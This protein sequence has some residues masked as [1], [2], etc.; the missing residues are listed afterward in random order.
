[1]NPTPLFAYTLRHLVLAFV[2]L[3]APLAA[4]AQQAAQFVGTWTTGLTAMRQEGLSTQ[5]GE[6]GVLVQTVRV[7]VGGDFARLRLSNVFGESELVITSA[8]LSRLGKEDIN[9]T[10]ASAGRTPV[11][12]ANQSGLSIPAGG[13]AVSDPLRFAIAADT[14]V[15]IT[16]HIKK[17]PRILTGH[18]SSGAPAVSFY[19]PGSAE[20][21]GKPFLRS[22]R[23]YFI[24]GLD[25]A[26]LK[27]GPQYRPR[28]VVA[29][30]DSITDG[31]GVPPS[32]NLRWSD[33]LSRRLRAHPATADVGVL[34]VGIGGNRLLRPGRGPSALQ[35]FERDVI[36][37]VGVR[38]VIVLIG[39]NDLGQ[40]H[41]ARVA[42]EEYPSAADLIA[43]YEQ[44]IARAH[45][46]GIKI[47]ASPIL[48]YKGAAFSYWSPEGEADRKTI[49]AWIRESGAF[50]AVID[51]DAVVRDSVDPDYLAEQYDL[52]DFVHP[53]PVGLTAMGRAIDLALFT[54]KD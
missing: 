24:S 34:N 50:D 10:A 28:A 18:D 32:G 27:A 39:V 23:W 26:P 43:G 1:M 12:F 45:A 40:A 29:F 15:V 46:A 8:V 35:R 14:D 7:S 2:L 13:T 22:N 37:Q 11:T 4:Q 36:Q 30:G 47:Y 33:E 17:A 49:N 20:A 25:T 3:A 9:A 53:S 31:Y 16:L 44:M 5:F 19:R 6:E 54:E 38:W 42:G 48:P 52:G 41:T 51:F 21:A